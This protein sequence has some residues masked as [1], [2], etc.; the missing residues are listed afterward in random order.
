[1]RER[2]APVVRQHDQGTHG[3]EG[4]MGEEWNEVERRRGRPQ[5]TSD[6]ALKGVPGREAG[7][8]EGAKSNERIRTGR[9]ARQGK[10]AALAAAHEALA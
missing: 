1:M 4:E 3:A 2:L 10:E 5:P 7:G 9:P 8:R 6:A